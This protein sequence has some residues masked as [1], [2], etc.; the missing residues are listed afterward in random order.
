LVGKK[1]ARGAEDLMAKA[2]IR[3]MFPGN[4]SSTGFY[5]FYDEVI[6]FPAAKVF[7]LKGGPGTG[8]STLMKKIGAV[9]VRQGYDLEY[10][11]CSS[12]PDSLDGLVIPSGRIAVLDGTRP[13]VIEPKNPGVVEEIVNLGDFW[14]EHLLLKNKEKIMELNKRKARMF[15][16]AYSHLREA[17]I[18]QDELESY[19][20]EAVDP[21]RV[22][23][24]WQ[25][26]NEAVFREVP[27]QFAQ[28]AKVRRLFASANTPGGYV[29]HLDS[30]LQEARLLYLLQGEPGTG[31]EEFL[32]SVYR[33]GTGRGLTCEVY[34]CP[35][36]PRRMEL[37]YF[38]P[39]SAGFLRV[40]EPLKFEPGN[41]PELQDCREVN[42][43]QDLNT[44]IL[45][46]YQQEIKEAKSRL[47][48]LRKKAWDKLKAAQ[49][50]H[51]H[52]EKLYLPAMD[53]E[54]VNRKGEEV[55]QKIQSYLNS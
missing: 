33:W 1:K 7:I 12:D 51:G 4:N 46:I 34:H 54:A 28:P 10:H 13:H 16:L 30:I 49:E 6:N 38:P 8:K 42:F 40:E 14:D 5:S 43:N 52:L 31:K 22:R 35:F 29:H 44:K 47:L 17:Q 15:Q 11:Y 50:V 53:F 39:L 2:K 9:M 48:A 3:K 23:K 20:Q 36:Q 21:V 55:L 37:L 27:P 24:L 26:V 32:K 25:Q 41:L 45:Q 19:Y 18:V